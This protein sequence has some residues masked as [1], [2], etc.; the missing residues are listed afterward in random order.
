MGQWSKSLK[1]YGEPA[2]EQL[3]SAVLFEL[4]Q[5]GA[6][7]TVE[8][9]C[10]LAFGQAMALRAG[11]SLDDMTPEHMERAGE[12]APPAMK[13]LLEMYLGNAENQPPAA[14]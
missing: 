4:A 6:L 10:F 2:L 14:D 11:V 3:A 9:V 13:K 5:R 8:G 12:Q 7:K 1:N